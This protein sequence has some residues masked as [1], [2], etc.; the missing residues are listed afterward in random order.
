MTMTLYKNR[1][2]IES[3]R[4]RNWNYSAPRHYFL[5]LCAA[6]K[7]HYF[8]KIV[9]GI[10][11]LS[12]VGRYASEHWTKVPEHFENVRLDE[13]VVMPNHLHGIIE[14]TGPEWE[15]KITSDTKTVEPPKPLGPQAGSISHIVRC[16]K[17][18]VSRWC[19]EQKAEFRWQAG[20]YDRIV[21]GPQSLA[22]IRNYIRENPVNW[23]KDT[24]RLQDS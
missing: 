4:L 24:E 2:R 22:A 23:D 1:Y 11:E 18:G 6:E 16:Y 3:I 15:P 5:T 9:N 7:R 10:V 21:R 19:K 13:F 14:L 20:F 8:G 17:A 12:D